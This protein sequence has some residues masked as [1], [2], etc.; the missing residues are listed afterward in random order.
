MAQFVLLPPLKGQAKSLLMSAFMVSFGT[1]CFLATALKGQAKSLL[2]PGY[3][4]FLDTLSSAVAQFVLLPP[5]KGQ[6]KS[7]LMLCQIS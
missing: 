5:L 7:L 1:I 3:A 2:M 4:K 6:A